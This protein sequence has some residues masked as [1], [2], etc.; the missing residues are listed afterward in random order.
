MTKIRKLNKN[1]ILY[2]ADC[3]DILPKLE[4]VD[5]CVMDPPYGL[6]EGRQKKRLSRGLLAKNTKYE[7]SDWDDKKPDQK[8]IDLCIKM[9]KWQIIF[10]GNYFNLPPTTCWL[11]WNKLNGDSDFADGEL[12]WTNLKGAVRIFNYRWQGMIRPGFVEHPGRGK[13]KAK[14]L[15]P[16]EKPE[17]VMNW[18]INKLPNDI[19]TIIDPFMGSGTTGISAIKLGY[20]FIGI[21]KNENY[22][23]IACERIE[24]ALKSNNLFIKKDCI[25]T[26]NVLKAPNL[27]KIGNKQDVTK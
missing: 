3:V 11:I 13:P 19:K 6:G 23:H 7:D 18:C 1:I 17:P 27:I 15:H 20:K 25:Q 8:L 22:F 4:K 16:T 26:E 10:G 2:N 5:A 24:K 9:S 21:E 12:A 14:R